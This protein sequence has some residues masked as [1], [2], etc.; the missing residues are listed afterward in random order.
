MGHPQQPAGRGLGTWGHAMLGWDRDRVVPGCPTVP[1]LG[2][3][4]CRP[5]FMG[6]AC[7][8]PILYSCVILVLQLCRMISIQCSCHKVH[9]LCSCAIL[10]LSYGCAMWSPSYRDVQ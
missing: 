5:H 2:F 6:C 7:V 4:L 3:V 8:D 10:S 1:V 9:V